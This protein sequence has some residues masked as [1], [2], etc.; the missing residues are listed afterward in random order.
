MFDHTNKLNM[1]SEGEWVSMTGLGVPYMT[2]MKKN[3]NK[4]RILL[5]VRTSDYI[6]EVRAADDSK[7][8]PTETSMH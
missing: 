3:T 2:A 8:L 5:S 1:K 4:R 7:M 6:Q